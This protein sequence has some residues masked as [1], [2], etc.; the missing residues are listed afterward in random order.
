[1]DVSILADCA[2]LYSG[3]LRSGSLFDSS[4]EVSA[5]GSRCAGDR[6]R[7]NLTVFLYRWPGAGCI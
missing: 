2:R 6:K 4:R 5:N 1:M 7:S 3:D